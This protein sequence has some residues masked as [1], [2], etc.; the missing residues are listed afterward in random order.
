MLLW[1]CKQVLV[2]K[3]CARV[4][5]LARCNNLRCEDIWNLQIISGEPP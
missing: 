2:N 1:V 4:N 3:I 5:V